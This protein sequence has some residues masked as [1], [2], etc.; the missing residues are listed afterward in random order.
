MRGLLFVAVTSL[1]LLGP[2]TPLAAQDLGFITDFFRNAKGI[3][4][5]FQVGQLNSAALMSDDTC[6]LAPVCGASGEI[7]IDLADFEGDL[8]V[9]LG[10]SA[11]YWRGFKSSN[12][13]VDLRGS[14]RNLPT[15]SAYVS[16]DYGRWSP[17]AGLSFGLSDLWNA[18]AYD[19]DGLVYG[20][21]AQ[22][23]DWGIMSALAYDLGPAFAFTELHYTWRRFT[24]LDWT[25]PDAVGGALPDAFPRALELSAPRINIGLQFQLN[26]PD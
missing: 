9:E 22:T 25:L 21:D 16:K 2:P 3:A 26:E 7:L 19:T 5:G 20:L 10:F 8:S 1:V 15:I 23:F 24:S 18:Q 12:P 14:I 6:P 4:I 17:Y 13:D 11:G